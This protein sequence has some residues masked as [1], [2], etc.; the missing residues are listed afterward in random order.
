MSGWLYAFF[1]LEIPSFGSFCSRW[2]AGGLVPGSKVTQP[3]SQMDLMP[4]LL[5][6]IGKRYSHLKLDGVSMLDQ[7]KKSKS[8]GQKKYGRRFDSR[9]QRVHTFMFHH[10]GTDIF[11]VRWIRKDGQVVMLLSADILLGPSLFC[12]ANIFTLNW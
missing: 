9:C 2:P 7:L 12:F 6:V 10:C 4:T 11:A 3:T 8:C 1:K 5:E